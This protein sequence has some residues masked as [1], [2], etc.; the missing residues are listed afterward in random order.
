MGYA[1]VLL[2]F[3]L[4]M[5]YIYYG[6]ECAL[7]GGWW[8]KYP[9][10]RCLRDEIYWILPGGTAR[11]LAFCQGDAKLASTLP[12]WPHFIGTHLLIPFGPVVV[13][14]CS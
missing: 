14:L 6:A 8:G 13:Y 4:G 3:G 11:K 10:L 1:I 2:L 12:G 9:H 5:W 7:N